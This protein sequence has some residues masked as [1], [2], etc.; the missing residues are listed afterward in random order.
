M[1]RVLFAGSPPL[2]VHPLEALWAKYEICGV[3]TN[4]DR[5]GG[6]G[7][8][9]DPTPVKLKAKELGLKIFQPLSLDDT[10]RQEVREL[11]PAIL[12]V[13]AYGR[14]FKK[15]F[16]DIFPYGGINLHPSIL[17]KFRGPSPIPAAILS[18]E[19][20][21]GVTIQRLAVKMD[22]GD[23]LTV[24]KVPLTG[25]ETTAGLS[26]RLGRIGAGLLVATLEMI[27][28]GTEEAKPQQ[29]EEATYCRLIKKEDGRI[30]WDDDAVKIERMIRA[31]DP[32]PSAFTYFKG[33]RLNI[34]NGGVY[35]EKNNANGKERG[36]VLGIDEQYGILLNT[37]RG[38]LYLNRLQL[39]AK[40]ELDWRSFLNGQKDFVGS[41]LGG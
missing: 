9:F 39:Q 30:R 36:L 5:P 14:I 19:K 1:I 24:G 37:G 15:K 3:L 29:E 13:A 35:P 8:R 21:T 27:A 38:V 18:G 25:K 32:W 41:L 33:Q 2:A 10:F 20:E 4:P 28:S 31:F 11:K 7:K 40:K 26:L 17:P 23:I 16:L 34:M 12:V 6:R 22:S